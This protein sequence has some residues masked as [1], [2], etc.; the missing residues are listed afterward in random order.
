MRQNPVEGSNTT[1]R[2]LMLC[3]SGGRAITSGGGGGVKPPNHPGKSNTGLDL[4][5]MQHRL[6]VYIFGPRLK[7]HSP[8]SRAW[9]VSKHLLSISPWSR[10]VK[11]QDCE[12]FFAVGHF[13][14]FVVKLIKTNVCVQC[15][16]LFVSI[17]KR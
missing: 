13:G 15:V 3:F 6:I 2:L 9:C 12:S 1:P 10:G 5:F 4:I 8:R 14:D 16:P 7:A 11:A 17:T